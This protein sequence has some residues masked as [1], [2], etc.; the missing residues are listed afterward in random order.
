M[1]AKGEDLD[2]W[3][4]LMTRWF[5]FAAF[6]PLFRVHG[7]YPYREMFY[8]APTDH[9]A[10]Q[11]MLYYDKLRYRLMPYIYSLTGMVTH[12]D[13]TIMRALVMDFGNDK[14][15]LNI[16]DQYMFGPAFLIN[17]VTE[18]NIRKRTVYLPEGTGWYELKSGKYFTGGQTIWADAPYTDI[19]IYVKEGS[20]IPFG[21]E[22]QYSDEKPANPLILYVYTGKNG[23]FELYEDENVNYNY[24]KG[25]FSIIPIK[26]DEKIHT[27]TIGERQGEF[28]GM[29]AIRTIHVVWVTK[30]KK[31]KLDFTIKPDKIL[32]YD[33]SEKSFKMD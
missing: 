8:V 30:D 13:Y 1:D 24:E 26:Y 20:I 17:P 28:P 16:G 2:E 5:Q 27:L 29:L 31:A 4:E 9:P 6:C 33:G 12:R 7:E 19:P 11:S 15:V 10:Y 22:I 23:G 21:P 3:R 25:K 18:Y 14:K 32:K